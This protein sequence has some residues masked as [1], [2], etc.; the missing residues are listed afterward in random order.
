MSPQGEHVSPELSRLALILLS[1]LTALGG[2]ATGLYLPAFPAM[3][4]DYDTD[5][6]GVH[7]TYWLY[8]IGFGVGQVIFGLISDR[9]G[10]RVPLIVASALCFVSSIMVALAPTLAFMAVCRVAQALGAAGGVVIAR[11]IVS[12]TATGQA[13]ARK[14]N[15]MVSLSM[16]APVVAP[17]LGSI[18]VTFLP[19][20][21]TL[22]MI[23]PV[24]ALVLVGVIMSIPETHPAHFRTPKVDVVDLLRV[25]RSGR[26]AAFLV[27]SAS[28]TGALLSY[29]GAAPFVYQ[30]ALGF[31]ALGFG[32]LYAINSLGMVGLTYL[33]S[34]LAHRGIHPARTLTVGVGILI[35]CAIAVWIV[36]VPALPI[37]LFVVSANHGLITGNASALALA[38]VRHI[39][40]AGSAALGGVQFMAGGVGSSVVGVDGADSAIPYFAVVTATATTAGIAL[41][42]SR[43]RSAH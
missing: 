26:Y 29:T 6:A 40:G 30:N 31:S 3:M 32:I 36:P 14:I 24:A 20:H 33:S 27:V 34:V 11:A 41:A 10:R 2:L 21:V 19:W 13:L 28:A 8:L 18:V 4:I 12:D 17:L 1:V 25:F 15:L 23:V 38:E 42:L 22:W 35:A 7:L 9:F 43:R 5:A 39:A 37:V 16:F